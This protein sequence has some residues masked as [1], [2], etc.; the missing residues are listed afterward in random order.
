MA[1]GQSPQCL[2]HS[3]TP[4][5]RRKPFMKIYILP[6]RFRKHGTSSAKAIAPKMETIPSYN[7]N[8]D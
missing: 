3:I 6:A 4:Q 1:A 2:P 8:R 5:N 7:P